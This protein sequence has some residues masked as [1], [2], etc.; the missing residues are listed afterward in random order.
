MADPGKPHPPCGGWTAEALMELVPPG[1]L[2]GPTLATFAVAAA[3]EM[4]ARRL[5]QLREQL[6][7]Q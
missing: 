1:G 7:A 3:L 5:G 2:D 4:I 6:A